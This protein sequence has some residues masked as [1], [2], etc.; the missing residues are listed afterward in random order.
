[1]CLFKKQITLPA[2]YQLVFL[3]LL[4][5]SCY[6]VPVSVLRNPPAKEIPPEGYALYRDYSFDSISDKPPTWE[7]NTC[8]HWGWK[9][10]CRKDG[11]I[12]NADGS[13]VPAN[14]PRNYVQWDQNQVSYIDGQVTLTT[15]VNPDTSGTPMLSGEISTKYEFN[16]G[17]YISVRAKVCP[18]GMQF[19][20]AG[21][22]YSMRNWPPEIDFFEFEC[23]DSRAFTT[24][25][26]AGNKTT[27]SKKH[28]FPVD[29]SENWHIYSVQFEAES[30]KFLLDNILLWN[31]TG[32]KIP[33]E[34]LYLLVGNGVAQSFNPRLYTDEVLGRIFPETM[35]V[36]FIRIYKKK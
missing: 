7:L 1:M 33:N 21:V 28:K 31:Y 35:Y 34:P 5:N 24:T 22:L 26:H 10:M 23:S 25:I 13:I 27:D 15:L 29:L 11:G 6:P 32:K 14:D 19:W 4:L 3:L 20:N 12:W 30:I 16:P 36:D 18:Q 9:G 2:E 17:T 8:E